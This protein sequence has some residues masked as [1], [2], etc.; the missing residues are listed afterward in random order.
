MLQI[1]S[2]LP[3]NLYPIKPIGKN[4]KNPL[5]MISPFD[6][7]LLFYIFNNHSFIR[8]ENNGLVVIKL[9]T[10][11][12]VTHFIINIKVNLVHNANNP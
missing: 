4:S 7:L 2:Q 11:G 9:V 3:I 6:L 8:I 12:T 10:V 1:N 5:T